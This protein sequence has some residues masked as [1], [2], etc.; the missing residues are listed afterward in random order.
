MWKL[1]DRKGSLKLTDHSELV[2]LYYCSVV[3][4]SVL[5]IRFEYKQRQRIFQKR[6]CYHELMNRIEWKLNFSVAIKWVKR[7][8]IE[9]EEIFS[10][11]SSDSETESRLYKE[12]K[13]LNDNN[14]NNI[15][16]KW[17][18]ELDMTKHG[19]SASN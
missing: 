4:K 12:F 17:A 1:L 10:I 14:P 15:A 3:S 2:H 6:E 16:N 8:P 18:N 13:T 5:N 7:Q 9:Q 11:Y 19:N